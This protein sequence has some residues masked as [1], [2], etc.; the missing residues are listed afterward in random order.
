MLYAIRSGACSA[1]PRGNS[2]TRRGIGDMTLATGLLTA[3]T[4]D[5]IE[6]Q[7]D[8]VEDLIEALVRV[9]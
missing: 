9:L 3:Q 7:T 1:V 5:T 4:S 6:N 8:G 2:W